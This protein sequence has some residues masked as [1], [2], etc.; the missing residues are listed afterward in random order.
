MSI[1]NCSECGVSLGQQQRQSSKCQQCFE[2]QQLLAL[3]HQDV[4]HVPVIIPKESNWQ[5]I[6]E[7]IT[8]NKVTDLIANK[9]NVEPIKKSVIN[10]KVI[11]SIAASVSFVVMGALT[12][13]NIQLEQKFEQVLTMNQLLEERLANQSMPYFS[14]A[15][16]S[17]QLNALDAQLYTEK[18][19]KKKLVILAQRKKVIENY[20]TAVKG[21]KNEFSI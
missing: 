4:E 5:V 7:S 10:F 14:H 12:W 17:K 21:S 20:L 19:L 9:T 13:H 2:E 8:D 1:V 16:I 18:N 3:L 11:T 6:K 15:S